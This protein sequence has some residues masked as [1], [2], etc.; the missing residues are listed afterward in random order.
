M[1]TAKFEELM[2]A[3]AVKDGENGDVEEQNV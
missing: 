2:S 1:N 3:T